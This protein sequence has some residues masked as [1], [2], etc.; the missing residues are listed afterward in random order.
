MTGG[1]IPPGDEPEDFGRDPPDGAVTAAEYALGLLEGEERAAAARRVLSDPDFAADVERWRAHFGTM[2]ADWPDAAAPADGLGRIERA[3]FAGQGAANDN[4]ASPR[5]WQG[6]AALSTA[7]AAALLLVVALRPAAGPVAAPPPVQVAAKPAPVLV[8]SIVPVKE[9]APVAALYDPASG[10]LRVGSAS[11]VDAGHSAEL[12]V[13]AK[14]GVPHSLGLIAATMASESVVAAPVRRG[15]A[16]GSTLAVTVEPIGGA[17][18]GKP[19]GAVIAT[20]ALV[21][22]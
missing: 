16:A 2:F 12:W 18:D 4:P 22:I 5:L 1:G 20:G 14:D 7:V 9:G 11:L 8:A 15:F 13:I 19:T 10:R 21:L 3:L 17:P 6:I